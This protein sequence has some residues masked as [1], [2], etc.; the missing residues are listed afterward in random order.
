MARTSRV[1]WARRVRRWRASGQ[2]AAAFAARTRCKVATLRWWAWRLASDERRPAAFV[3]ATALLEPT[4][5]ALPSVELHIGESLR[6]RV[7][8]GFDAKLLREVVLALVAR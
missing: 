1:E 2:S 3:D 5:A 6:I 4:S 7:S 8:P